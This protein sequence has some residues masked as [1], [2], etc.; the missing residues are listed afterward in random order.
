MKRTFSLLSSFAKAS[1]DLSAENP[2]FE[3]RKTLNLGGDLYMRS[4]FS[5]ESGEIFDEIADFA[6][7]E[8]EAHG[9][10][11]GD[12]GG[13]LFDVGYFHLGYFSFGV[14]DFDGAVLFFAE[15]A[16]DG[17]AIFE[18]EGNGAVAIGDDGLG[19]GEGLEEVGAGA[20]EADGFEVGADVAS[21]ALIDL[22]AADALGGE[23]VHEEVFSACCAAALEGVGEVGSGASELSDRGGFREIELEPGGDGV[24]GGDELGKELVSF[25]GGEGA[26]EQCDGG[27]FFG[28][29]T[30]L[31]LEDFGSGLE[32]VFGIGFGKE[33]EC[34]DAD[35]D[36]LGLES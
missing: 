2:K 13:A 14:G 16:D 20:L 25:F 28:E 33:H 8:N 9:G 23:V 18:G 30:V 10:H 4:F 12:D 27:L 32:G 26:G 31:I 34:F 36:F 3:R 21:L 22:V 29:V 35:V 5:F 24:E 6:F 19:F 17:G 15:L 7:F 11:G 1:A